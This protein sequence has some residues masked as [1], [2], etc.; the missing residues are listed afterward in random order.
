MS[1]LD[2]FN[3]SSFGWIELKN[4][5]SNPTDTDS[6][7][8]GIAVVSDS[9]KVYDG[10]SWSTVSGSATAYDDIGNPDA[11][12]SISF[13][14]YTA[15]YTSS[16]ANWGGMIVSN[17][18]TTPTSGATLLSLT[19]DAD[20]DSDGVYLLCKDNSAGDTVFQI[21]ADGATT[22]TGSASGTDALAITAGDITMSSGDLI[23]DSGD[24]K[25]SADNQKLTLGAADATDSY[26][27]FD[28]SDLTFYDSNLGTTIT[29]SSLAGGNPAGDF[30]IS[31]GQFSWTDTNDE[32][33]GT[34]TF[35]GTTNNDIDWS[36]AVTTG[37][38]LA[39]V[40]DALTT[41][42]MIYLESS[43][44]G[45]TSGKYIRCYDGSA[46]DFTVGKYGATIIAG[47][48]STDVLT[49]SAGDVQITEG[50]IDLDDG[51]VTIDTDNDEGNTIK[52]NNATGTNP[53]LEVEQSH[54][55]GGVAFLVDQDA[56]GDVNAIEITNAG[57]GFSLT[58]TGGAAGS[59]GFEFISATGGT[60]NGLLLDGTTNT[61]VGAASTGF[62]Q[63]QSDGTL[64]DTSA[65]LARLAF[66]GT[67]ASGGA[68]T[69]LRVEDTST[70]GGGTE[71]AVYISSTNSEALHVDAGEV[72]LD[73]AL[74]LGASG[75]AAG[76]DFLAYGN[77]NG[78]AVHWDE[79][80]DTLV[81]QNQ[82]YL[83]I[84]GTAA[85]ADGVTFDFDGSSLDIDAV[86]ANDTITFG[87][88]VDT[89][90]TF[91]TANAT[92]EIDHGAD[93]MTVQSGCTL[94]VDGGTTAGD[95]LVIPYHATSSPSG[96]T[97]GSIF[98]EVDANKLW[99]YNGTGWVGVTLS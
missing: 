3:K 80:T 67:S 48:A 25:V 84:G 33:A 54:I 87:S 97:T 85:S 95:G 99:V 73:E 12:G 22:I 17:T 41:G 56:T 24:I 45:L 31:D 53:V 40:A 90:V 89:N 50:D 75:G 20:G 28:G 65:T 59:E 81:L 68:G 8:A 93:T 9:L 14:A 60:G 34:W 69:C 21:G 36:S 39:M 66:S 37:S 18:A 98:F 7:R 47:N 82:T 58:S 71:Y 29:L 76:A 4:Y 38:A 57:T 72:L 74:T 83:Q 94:I 44:S 92:I 70:S 35:A 86:T 91:T 49:V 78:K 64:A 96:T 16:T 26:L 11:S 55:T 32:V 88:D 77:T 63:V 30:T 15:T 61:W 79:G 51:I 46:N 43:V 23:V 27:T 10:S 5:S 6:N 1:D 2:N 62:L 19:Y 52:R 42:D 13:G